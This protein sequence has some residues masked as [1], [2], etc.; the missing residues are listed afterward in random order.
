VKLDPMAAGAE[1]FAARADARGS[2][3]DEGDQREDRAAAPSAAAPADAAQ[4]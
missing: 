3:G 2:G 4:S 1:R